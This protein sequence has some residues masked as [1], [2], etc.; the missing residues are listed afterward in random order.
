[1]INERLTLNPGDPVL[2]SWLALVQTR[3]G[4]FREAQTAVTQA[5][6]QGAKI[7]SVLYN[8]ARVYALQRD[9]RQSLDNLR[10][11]VLQKYDLAAVL[12]MD[13]F[14]LHGNPDFQ[15]SVTL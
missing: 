12:D 6:R 4:A 3:L 8:A 1:V 15:T 9:A 5:L 7:P 10:M 14:N 13:L 2:L 11:A